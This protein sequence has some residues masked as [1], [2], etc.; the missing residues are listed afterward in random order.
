MDASCPNEVYEERMAAACRAAVAD[1]FS[2]SRL[3]IWR[4][5][6]LG[7]DSCVAR[8]GRR[9]EQVRVRRP[10]A[11]AAGTTEGENA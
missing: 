4:T 8:R 1:G 3:E 5:H 2:T 6:V 7:A 9:A 11:V 10:S